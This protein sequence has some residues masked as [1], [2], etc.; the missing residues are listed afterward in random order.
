MNNAMS[1]SPEIF[2]TVQSGRRA[3]LQIVKNANDGIRVFFQ[4][5][6]LP[7]FFLTRA[8]ENKPRRFS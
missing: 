2:E 1:N 8:A 4:L 6:L 3:G 5:Q 7:E